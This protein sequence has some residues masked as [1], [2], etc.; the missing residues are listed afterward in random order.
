METPL[1][2]RPCLAFLRVARGR[3]G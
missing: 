3:R 2:C 1:G